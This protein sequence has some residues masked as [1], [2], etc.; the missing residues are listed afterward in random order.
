[1]KKSTI[2]LT[3]VCGP[4]CSGKSTFV[5]SM[6]RKG[7]VVI[8]LDSIQRKINPHFRPWAEGP[9]NKLLHRAI[10]I[11]NMMLANLATRSSGCAWFIVGAP[12][13]KERHWW[14]H[15]LGGEVV[16]LNPGIEECKRR[17][18]ARGTPL[19]AQGA[20][21]WAT[22]AEMYWVPPRHRRPIHIDG[23]FADE[24]TDE[25]DVEL[26]KGMAMVG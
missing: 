1:L 19:A 9:N 16:L 20:I 13:Q 3:I 15:K 22:R 8:D 18:Y 12:S 14:Q 7:D 11:R 26:A 10:K 17:A 5:K 23:W 25:A 6:F 21:M 24:D 4:P 2:P